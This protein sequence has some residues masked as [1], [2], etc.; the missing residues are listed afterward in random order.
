M[1]LESGSEQVR[2]ASR[3]AT[4]EPC[5]TP[6]EDCE[7]AAQI[8]KVVGHKAVMRA[9][10]SG[11]IVYMWWY[12]VYLWGLRSSRIMN[13]LRGGDSTVCIHC[14]KILFFDIY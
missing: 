11:S 10:C 8:E 14:D 7:V 12:S 6:E 13:T 9:E 5:V 2:L 3:L 1:T 4:V